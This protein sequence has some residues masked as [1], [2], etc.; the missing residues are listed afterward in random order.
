MRDYYAVLG[1]DRDAS[2]DEIKQAFRRLAR[3]YHP[4]VKK[5]DPQA[6]ERF[7]EINEAYQVLSDPERRA[8]YDRFGTVPSP[9]ADLRDT[10]FGPF[11]DLFD[12]FF[13]RRERVSPEA[14]ER[15]ADLRYDLELTL[16]E[17]A[18]GVEKTVEIT[19]LDTCPSCFGTGAERGSAP[20]TCTTCRGA[21][22]VRY[23]QRTIFGSFTQVTTCPTCGGSGKVIPRP[24]RTCRGSGRAE[25][26]RT[27]SVKVPAGVDHGM[28]LRLAGEGE[29]GARGGPRGDLY[30]FIHLKPHPVFER[31]G[32]DLFSSFEISMTQAA[33]GAEV[34]IPTLEGPVAHRIPAGVQPGDVLTLKGKGM[35]DARG[36]RGDLHVRLD[37]RVPTDL[38][39]E[40]R[41]VLLQFARLRGEQVAPPRKKLSA[42]VKDLL[43]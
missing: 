5:D 21:G 2:Q 20:E 7:K 19:R 23:A 42:R 3:Q 15:G 38:S 8:H 1:V 4:D 13:G 34:Q 28:R 37:V 24:C 43:Q 33:L 27:L 36:G 40:E 31:R 6:D 30:V 29:S 11:E 14:P 9:G 12:M 26:R 16:E 25:Q 10:G 17:A 41:Q 35:P 32:R 18:A 22:E 39:A